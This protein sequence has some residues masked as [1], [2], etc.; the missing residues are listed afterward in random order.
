MRARGSVVIQREPSEVFRYISDPSKD[1]SWRSY[2][3]SSHAVDAPLA[4]GSIIRQKYSYQ[5]HAAEAELEVTAYVPPER[6]ELRTRGQIKGRVVCTCAA[7]S[8]GTRLSMSGSGEL[9]GAA[10]MFESRVQRE[11]DQTIATDLKRLK[12]VLEG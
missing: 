3:V 10:S 9:T 12:T 1:L 11:V 6:L 8:G 5:G 2:L 7:E 4:V